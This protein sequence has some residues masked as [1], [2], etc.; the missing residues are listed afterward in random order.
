M[1]KMLRS[2]RVK[3]APCLVS[4]HSGWMSSPAHLVELQ[5][6]RIREQYTTARLTLGVFKR[7]LPGRQL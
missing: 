6:Q 4:S 5:G 1:P 3:P 7:A 2:S